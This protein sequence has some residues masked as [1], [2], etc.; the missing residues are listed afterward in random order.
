LGTLLEILVLSLTVTG[1]LS[2]GIVG[3]YGVVSGIL[4]TFSHHSR[5]EPAPQPVL[6]A[7]SAQAGGD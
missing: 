3:A 1:A 2:V 4:Y 5:P 7:R 6:L